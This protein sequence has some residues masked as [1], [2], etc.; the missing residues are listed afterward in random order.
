MAYR[1]VRNI[2]TSLRWNNPGLTRFAPGR[3]RCCVTTPLLLIIIQLN[4]VAKELYCLSLL[5]FIHTTYHCCPNI[6][7]RDWRLHAHVAINLFD[8]QD[9]H[10][11]GASVLEAGPLQV[12]TSRSIPVALVFTVGGGAVLIPI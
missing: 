9:A 11:V 6:L 10:C 3:L 1:A 5:N 7:D 12:V 8:V 4:T 2:G